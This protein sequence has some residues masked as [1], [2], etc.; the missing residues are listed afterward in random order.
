MPRSFC[1]S[2]LYIENKREQ[3]SQ[4]GPSVR[5]SL[6]LNETI[7]AKILGESVKKTSSRTGLFLRLSMKERRAGKRHC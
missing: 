7:M 3:Q 1:S 2:L 4:Y 6:H 5:D